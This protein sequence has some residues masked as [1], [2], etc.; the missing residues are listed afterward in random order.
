MRI[1]VSFNGGGLTINYEGV[2]SIED[3]GNIIK[4][5]GPMT[6]VVNA[7]DICTVEHVTID[8]QWLLTADEVYLDTAI[9]E[10]SFQWQEE[11]D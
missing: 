9:K 7:T 3:Y 6:I 4:L 11:H 5:H 1:I 2:T 10:D 8:K